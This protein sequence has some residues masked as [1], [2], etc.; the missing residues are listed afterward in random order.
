[1]WGP[2]Y[3]MVADLGDPSRSRWQLTTGQSGHPGSPH[4]DDMIDGWLHGRT[5]P[6]YLEEHEIRAAGG[7]RHLRLH[8]D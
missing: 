6:A 1:V 7:A 4:Y 5:N 2:V 8:H 3:R